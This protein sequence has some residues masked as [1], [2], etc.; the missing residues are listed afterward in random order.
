MA[1][2]ASADSMIGTEVGVETVCDV[3]ERFGVERSEISSK[4]EASEMWEKN[5]ITFLCKYIIT[6]TNKLGLLKRSQITE[7]MK[8]GVY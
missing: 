3:L 5:D 4:L 2:I 7:I 1:S 6:K 8:Q